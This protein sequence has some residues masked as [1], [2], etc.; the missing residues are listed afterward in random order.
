MKARLPKGVGGGAP[1]N[2][3]QMIKQAQK[4]QEEMAQAQELLNDKEY[5]AS[6]GGGMVDVIITG[7]KEVKSVKIKP[8]VMDPN[9]IEMLED[10]IMGAVNEALRSAEQDS[11]DTMGAITG[12]LNIPG[13][14]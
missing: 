2:M 8:E 7:N 6:A 14:F 11:N 4:M 9:D 10:L 12:D 13:M 1:S 5:S 3:N